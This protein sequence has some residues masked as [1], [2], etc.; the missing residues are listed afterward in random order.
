MSEDSELYSGHP[1]ENMI[2]ILRGQKIIL[3]SDLARIY[4][5]PTKVLNQAVK[6]NADRFPPDFAFQLID[7]EVVRLRSQIVTSNLGRG[8]RR[9]N[10]YAFTKHGAIQAANILNS[11]QAIRMGVFVV[12]AFVRLRE[13]LA[14][15]KNMARKLE[16]LEKKVGHQDTQIQEVFEAIRQL[17]KP[18]EK[19]KRRIGFTAEEKKAVYRAKG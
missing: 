8:G 2:I 5:V 19:P 1:V 18:P 12:R 3:D 6:R 9:Y 10:P 7:Q 11:K 4:G 17:M 15:H 13:A 16:A 14:V